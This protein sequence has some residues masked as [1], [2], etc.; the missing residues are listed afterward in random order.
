MSL[1]E[2][3]R[4]DRF[5]ALFG[6]HPPVADK[7]MN[8][9]TALTAVGPTYFLPVFDAMIRAGIDGGLTRQAATAAAAETSRGCADMVTRRE[10]MPEQLKLYTGLRTLDDAAVRALVIKAIPDAFSRTESVQR[11]ATS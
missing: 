4:A 10:E 8:L 1:E 3:E 2:R 11:Q 7:E 5:L 9:Y 6:A